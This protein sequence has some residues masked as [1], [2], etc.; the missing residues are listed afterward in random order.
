MVNH[1]V[2][3]CV[4][5]NDSDT[6]NILKKFVQLLW[7]FNTQLPASSGA[8]IQASNVK[9]YGKVNWLLCMFW[10]WL[11]SAAEVVSAFC[12]HL[13]FYVLL[14]I[15]SKTIAQH[16][17]F[18]CQWLLNVS[19]LLWKRKPV[20]IMLIKKLKVA[21]LF[22]VVFILQKGYCSTILKGANIYLNYL[23]FWLFM[24]NTLFQL[25]LFLKS[26]I[27]KVELTY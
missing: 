9:H 1:L 20:I 10:I 15:W 11:D 12:T 13:Q 26:S 18:Q 5:I 6:S 19:F 23:F 22:V 24:Y 2:C 25:W 7:Y 14:P 27:N 8:F 17:M 3:C 4:S 21:W 16:R